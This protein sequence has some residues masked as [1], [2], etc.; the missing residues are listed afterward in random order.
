M[1]ADAEAAGTTL[2]AFPWMDDVTAALA[3]EGLEALQLGRGPHADLLAVSLSTTDAV[4]HRFGPDSRELHD[5]V[6]RVDRVI[7]AFIDSVYKLRDSSRVV[8]ALTSDHGVA[9]IPELHFREGG[10][11]R[12]RVDI[13]PVLDAHKQRLAARGV[14][15]AAIDFEYG[16]L[17]LDR[18]ALAGRRVGADSLLRA[19]AE[20]LRAVPGVLRVDV[21]AELARAPASDTIARRWRHAIPDDLPA[22]LVVTQR[23][24]YYWASFAR[25]GGATGASHGS[26]HT[27][28]TH[29]PVIFYGPGFRAGKHGEYARVVDMAP[30]LARALGVRPTE[31]LDGVVLER[32]LK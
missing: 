14:D 24:Y 16:L 8:F 28:D 4:G 27:Y 11:R 31:R 12:G 15:S 19:L 25:W 20:D 3:L 10:D 17:F 22:E 21:R 1:P 23:P 30:T 18:Q 2:A 5:Q 9:P 32:A 6:L 7:G 29:V 13:E 26:V